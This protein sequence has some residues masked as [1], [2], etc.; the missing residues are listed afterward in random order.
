[1]KRITGI[2]LMLAMLIT[3]TVDPVNMLLLMVPL[4]ALYFLSILFA[5]LAEKRRHD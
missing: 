4:I 3:P 5:I 2:L 1:M